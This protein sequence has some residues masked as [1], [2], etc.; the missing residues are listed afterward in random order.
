MP[1]FQLFE[2]IV[3]VC[4]S[5]IANHCN[6]CRESPVIKLPYK[7]IQSIR[8]SLLCFVIRSLFWSYSRFC[9][10]LR[11]ETFSLYWSRLFTTGW[12]PFLMPNQ[13]CQATAGNCKPRFRPGIITHTQPFNGL[14][15]GTTSVRSTLHRVTFAFVYWQCHTWFPIPVECILLSQYRYINLI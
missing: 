4:T 10:L 15:S 14:C 8:W 11:N 6:W 12:M 13:Q 7:I 3:P 5:N 9:Q 2:D 1:H